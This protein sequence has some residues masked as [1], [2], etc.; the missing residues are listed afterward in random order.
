MR[1]YLLVSFLIGFLVAAAMLA[2]YHAGVFVDLAKWLGKLYAQIGFF[3]VAE[4]GA[5]PG[6]GSQWIWMENLLIVAIA[7]GAT[8]CVI[9]IPQV[10]HKMLV[11]LTILV[12]LLGLSPTLALYGVLYEPFSCLATALL[13]T[14]SGIFYA[15][16]EHG[17]RKRLL[18]NVLGARVSRGTFNQLMDSPEPLNFNGATREMSVLTCRIFNHAELREKVSPADVL[19][20]SNLF[21]RNTADFLM[22]RGGYL[23][24]SSPDLVRVF[25][26]IL[27]AT[28]RHAHDACA[29]ALELRTRL[30]N[31]NDECETRW[32]QRL[33]YGVAISSGTMTVGVYGS[34][35]HFYF[36]G[37]GS[38]TDFSRRLAQANRRYGSDLLVS[39]RT[40]R[41]VREACEVRP[42]EMFYDPDRNMMSEVYQL[43]ATREGFAEP[44]RAR[45]DAFWQGVILYRGGKYAEALDFFARAAHPAREDGPLNFFVERARARLTNP[46]AARDENSHELTDQ[47][48]ARMLNMM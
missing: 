44:D 32:F 30:R 15:G 7:F 18:Q 29:A 12:V 21:L 27:Q 24:E 22:S 6:S 48:H 47:G 28:E 13:A 9:D 3:P 1:R 4:R 34:R 45:R 16:S 26:G 40:H 42:M 36:S 43:L 5:A 23:D 2:L 19:A 14:A 11:F 46:A 31:L 20:M 37:L 35:R 25:F 10:G 41:L 33:D 17:M 8:W 38:E 39:A